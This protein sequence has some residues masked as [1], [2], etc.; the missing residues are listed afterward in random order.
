M[1]HLSVS[2]LERF[3][4]DMRAETFAE[5]HLLR[6]NACCCPGDTSAKFSGAESAMSKGESRREEILTAAR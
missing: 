5:L 2:L 3:D 4:R 1:Y 6:M